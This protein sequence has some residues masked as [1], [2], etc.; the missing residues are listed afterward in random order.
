MRTLRR[1]TSPAR[2]GPADRAPDAAA[3]DVAPDVAPE[4]G[5][6]SGLLG[7]PGPR[8]LLL[9]G[10]GL[11]GFATVYATLVLTTPG[12][13]LENLALLGAELRSDAERARSLGFLS[14]ISVASLAL[15][16]ALAFIVGIARRRPGLGALA[17]AVMG[18]S[19][20]L[21]ELLKLA[22]PRPALVDGASWILRGSFPSGSAAVATSIAV[23]ALM[24]APDRM[25]WLVLPAAASIA[26][27][28]GEAIQVA[29]WHR[30]SDSIGASLLVA[31]VAGAG[32][33]MLARTGLVAPSAAGFVDRRVMRLVGSVAVAALVVGALLLA[34]L[35]G[36]PV[37]SGPAGARRAFLQ[38]AFPLLGASVTLG[39]LLLVTAAVEPFTLGRARRDRFERADRASPRPRADAQVEPVPDDR[40]RGS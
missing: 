30:L 8:F 34:L 15:A 19:V 26:V 32:L 9:A 4:R 35:A 6:T 12:Q 5:P 14:Q 1:R 23:A 17:A 36:F 10:A 31:A 18:V 28:V 20:V 27:L 40:R 37:L 16:M 11:A 22:L 7:R 24:V 21:A 29:G 38:A 25:R 39:V 3:P 2:D 13:R 33:A